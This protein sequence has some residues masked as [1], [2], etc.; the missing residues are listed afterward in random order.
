MLLIEMSLSQLM[1]GATSNITNK[2][3]DDRAVNSKSKE[4]FVSAHLYQHK[5]LL[6]L[7]FN[8]EGTSDDQK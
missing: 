4:V 7:V 5:D 3:R 1:H 6:E 8:A 2:W